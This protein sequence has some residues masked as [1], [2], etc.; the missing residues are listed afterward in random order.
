MSGSDTNTKGTPMKLSIGF[1]LVAII[2][3]VSATGSHANGSWVASKDQC[4]YA[5][6]ERDEYRI[7]KSKITNLEFECTIKS[8]SQKNGYNVVK[9]S[10][11]GEGI[12][13]NETIRYKVD[14]AGALLIK[15]GTQAEKKY[16]YSCK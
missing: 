1:A 3:M 11:C 4:Q 2:L 14:S 6:G 5:A 8:R 16:S 10:C 13:D 12:C 15:I 9:A 7:S